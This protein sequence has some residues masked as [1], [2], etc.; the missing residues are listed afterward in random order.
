MGDQVPLDEDGSDLGANAAPAGGLAISA[1]DMAALASGPAR[2]RQDPRDGPRLF[3]EAQSKADV[4]AP[5][6]L[7]PIDQ[8][9]GPSSTPTE[10]MFATYALGWNVQD[11]RGAK[12]IWHGGAV[13]G[14][15]AA[16]ALMPDRTSASTS[17]STARKAR[18]SAA[19]CTNCS[20]IISACRAATG[21]SKLHAFRVARVERGG[22]AASR[23]Q[24]RSRPRS[25]P[26]CRSPAMPATIHDPWYGTIKI[27]ESAAG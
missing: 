7:T 9:P 16:V 5:V 13:F 25:D 12:L 23:A 20:T 19:S 27:R 6:M 26:R 10:P 17:P 18:W 14:S 15:L 21:P 2:A 22:Q 24:P 4:A 8:F 11:Y 1:N 3:S